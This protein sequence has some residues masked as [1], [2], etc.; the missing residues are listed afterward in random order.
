MAG[1]LRLSGLIREEKGKVVIFAL[2]VPIL[3]GIFPSAPQ[4]SVINH[5]LIDH[6][7]NRT[8]K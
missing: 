8:L 3:R 4:S 6:H 1:D 7:L 5:H 2:L